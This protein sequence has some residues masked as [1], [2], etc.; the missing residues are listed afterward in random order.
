MDFIIIYIYKSSK[1]TLATLQL[2][3]ITDNQ[4]RETYQISDLRF[5]RTCVT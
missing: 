4:A 2:C 5:F 3:S 1:V